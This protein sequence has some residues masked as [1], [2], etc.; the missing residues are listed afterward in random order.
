M[1]KGK[2]KTFDKVAYNNDFNAKNY[3]RISLMIPKGEKEKIKAFA[4]AKGE[5][6]NGF[7]NRLISEAM[8]CEQ[9]AKS[10]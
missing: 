9:K 6:L 7:I 4:E 5:S 2:E 1:P 8:Q 10:D 3:D